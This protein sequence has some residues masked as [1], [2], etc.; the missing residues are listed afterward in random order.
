MFLTYF[1]QGGWVMYVILLASII[2]LAVFIERLFY[3]SKVK[4][5]AK[6]VVEKM[7]EKL[8]G[9]RVDEAI[10]VCENYPGPASNIIHAGLMVADQKREIIERSMEDAAKYE[11]PKLN[12]NL[13]VLSTIVSISTLLGLLGTV[14]GMIVSSS[15]LSTQGMSDPSKLIGGIAQALITTAAGLIV[16]IP[17]LIGY[18]YIVAKIDNIISDIEITTTEIIRLLKQKEVVEKSPA[19]R[20]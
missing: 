6:M 18:N 17:A 5:N 12:R 3:L 13:P 8:R 9:M 14:L 16:A 10:A 11:I 7:R 1:Q 4:S 15:V 19:S 2:A 20:W